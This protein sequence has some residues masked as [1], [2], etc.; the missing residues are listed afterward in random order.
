MRIAYFD[1]DKTLLTKSSATLYVKFLLRRRMISFREL[2]TVMRISAAYSLNRLDFPKAMARMSKIIKGG[3]ATATKT[4]CDR[5][6]K[7]ELLQYIA[8]KA[9]ARVREHQR[10]GDSVWLISA[11]TQFVVLPVAEHIGIPA[12]YTEIEIVGGKF[13]GLIVD[14]PCYGAGKVTWAERIA[15]DQGSSLS[16]CV[17][18]TDSYS[19]RPLLDLVGEPIAVNPDGKLRRYATERGWKIELFY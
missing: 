6:V 14:E 11:S 2:L 7:E 18:Y 4:M 10:Q 19:D 5:W 13:T 3:D 8:P 12:R 17:F 16:E 15:I 9:L 1:M